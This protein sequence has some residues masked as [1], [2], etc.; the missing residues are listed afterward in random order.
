MLDF[1]QGFSP[2]THLLIT[3]AAPSSERWLHGCLVIAACQRCG[4]VLP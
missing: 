1:L 4:R 2:A 3:I